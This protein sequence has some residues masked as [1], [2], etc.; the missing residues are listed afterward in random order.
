MDYNN[1]KNAYTPCQIGKICQ[2]FYND[3][4]S[5]IYLVPQWCSYDSSKSITIHSGESI[6]WNGSMD[7][8]GDLIVENNATLTVRCTLSIPPGG[9]IILHPKAT[10]ILDGCI[11][12]SRCTGSFDGIEIITR[13]KNKPM[14]HLMNGAVIQHVKHPL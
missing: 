9:K 1:W 4:G 3:R 8:Y 11:V 2:N 13:K 6:E 5:R 14:I 12:T 7:V 10:L